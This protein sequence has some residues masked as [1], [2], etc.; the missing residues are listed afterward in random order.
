MN[1]RMILFL[2][3]ICAITTSCNSTK[4]I[5]GKSPSAAT[6]DSRKLQQKY[7][8]LLALPPENIT[9]FKLYRFLDDWMGTP[10]HYGGKSKSGVDCSGFATILQR[11]VYGRSVCC[12]TAELFSQCRVISQRELKEGDLVFFNIGGNK[13]TH[14]G[15]YLANQ[16]FAHAS[17]QRGVIISDL[18]EPYYSNSFFKAGRI[19]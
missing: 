13:I 3:G 17:T 18:S 8:A 11:D 6:A 19:R 9:N 7:S 10:Y 14:V 12:S 1:Y 2:A 15:V 4:Q 5:S 16:K